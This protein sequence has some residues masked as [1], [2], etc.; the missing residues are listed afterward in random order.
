MGTRGDGPHDYTCV[1][2]WW[3]W[4]DLGPLVLLHDLCIF[5]IDQEGRDTL[6]RENAQNAGNKKAGDDVSHK[7]P[8]AS[9]STTAIKHPR[10]P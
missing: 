9:L 7:Q 5:L 3:V 4:V 6:C 1:S 10:L 8:L 2:V